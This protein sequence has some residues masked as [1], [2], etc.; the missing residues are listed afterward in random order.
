MLQLKS[1]NTHTDSRRFQNPILSNRQVIQT[2]P[3]QKNARANR[4]YKPNGSNRYLKTF[5]LNLNEHTFFSA[6]QGTFSK[7]D[8][9]YWHKPSLNRYMKIEINPYILSNHH[10]LKL[11]FNNRNNRKLINTLKLNNCLLNK[12]WVRTEIEN[13]F[14]YFLEYKGNGYTAFPNLWDI[15][16]VHNT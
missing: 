5:Q 1:C 9:I 16:K 12:K 4:C 13:E 6:T 3:K 15:M 14:N 11:D 7:I 10:G 2:K 8:H